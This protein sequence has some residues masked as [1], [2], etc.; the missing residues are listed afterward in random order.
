MSARIVLAVG[1]AVLVALFGLLP[2]AGEAPPPT[3][4]LPAA[5]E[6]RQVSELLESFPGA[7][8]TTAVVL[9]HRDA[10]LTPADRAAIT[11]RAQNLAARATTP[12]AVRPQFSDDA[13]AAL[14][15]LPLDA[16]AVDADIAGTA[17]Q[18]RRDA[19][20]NLPDGLTAQLTGPVGFRADT[21]GAFAGTDVKLLLVTVLVVALLLIVTYRSP[22]L[23][24]VPLAVVGAAD[25]L[26]RLVVAALAARFDIAV[27][28]STFGIQSVLVFGAGTNYAMLLI[29]RY[30]EELLRHED[31]HAAMRVAV[32][33]AGP[34][35]AAS[36]GTV[37]LSLLTLLFAELAGSR[38]LGFAC[39]LG[40]VIAIL[41]AVLLL[42]AAL[43][44]FG[45]GLFWPF[46]PR[47][48]GAPG[49]GR[50]GGWQRI[51]RGVARR[52]KTVIAVCLAVLAVS[53]LGLTGVRFGLSQ[54]EQLLGNPESVQAQRVLDQSFSAGFSSQTTVLAPAASAAQAAAIATGTAGVQA[55]RT[56][57]TA[58]ERT[59][60]DVTLSAAPGTDD[61][62]ATI[63]ALRA[64][65]ERAG[66]P[67]RSTLVG[68]TDATTL[69]QRDSM[70]RDQWIV[71]PAILAI[72]FVILTLL[73]R[74]LLAPVLLLLSVLATYGASL[75]LGNLLFRYVFDFPALDTPVPL[76]S[77]LFL[78]ALGVDY[79][80]FLAARA[81]EERTQ[82]GAR[83]GMI[84]ALGATGGVITSAGILLAAVFVVLGVLP[85]VALAQNGTLVCIG[86]LLDTLMVRTLLV[87]ALAFLT[88][89]AFWWPARRSAVQAQSALP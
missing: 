58:R 32:R 34:T 52:P 82:H 45:R 21:A 62:F 7:D 67:L 56:G 31:R 28:A 60:I 79:N 33:S 83:E 35:I 1:L 66:E 70:R 26:A 63:T 17:D 29:A 65:Y 42:P 85:V 40:V 13:K 12:Q 48:D 76:Y 37:A 46:V 3:A 59:R 74:S 8:Q 15:P 16:A 27:D 88:G 84:V 54:T 30:R 51:G 55:V 10:G 18:L 2:S 53:T 11:E 5:S 44:I 43:V 75:G 25:G 23:W 50:G 20:A 77:F 69:D 64:A 72:V 38:A 61:A 9:F 73:L 22:V 4:G 86:V 57:P 41:V 36:G 89:D 71:I 19:G 80:I 14:V 49:T 39:A 81:R 6:A 47:H 68:G 87:P 24:I 78:V